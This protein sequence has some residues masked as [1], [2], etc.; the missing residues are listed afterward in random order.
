MIS[1]AVDVSV[2]YKKRVS[3]TFSVSENVGGFV[4]R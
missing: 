2:D 4:Q 3:T 1:S